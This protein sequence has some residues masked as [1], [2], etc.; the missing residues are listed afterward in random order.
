MG[1][2]F[3][4]GAETVGEPACETEFAR[5]LEESEAELRG[6]AFVLVNAR[7]VSL[8]DAGIGEAEDAQL[9]VEVPLDSVAEKVDEDENGFLG[10]FVEIDPN[11]FAIKLAGV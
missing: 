11:F 7:E 2:E 10:V 8:G 4:I 9:F 6:L 3:P 5:L 1:E